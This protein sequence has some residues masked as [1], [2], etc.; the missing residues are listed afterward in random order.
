MIHL[1]TL[2]HCMPR[3]NSGGD[4]HYW[5]GI[6]PYGLYG[7]T[8]FNTL[9][10]S[11]D[12]ELQTYTTNLIK[13]IAMA[14]YISENHDRLSCDSFRDNVIEVCYIYVSLSDYT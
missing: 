6:A 3:N 4:I 8:L 9:L 11:C 2:H 7:D 12:Q 14:G 1:N 10:P 5:S 13:H